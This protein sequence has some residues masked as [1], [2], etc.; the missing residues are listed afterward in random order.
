MHVLLWLSERCPDEEIFP[1]EVSIAFLWLQVQ[2]IY[3][4]TIFI[5][6]D[7]DVLPLEMQFP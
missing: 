4:S 2:L 7:K 1:S 5:Y 6:F 3:L